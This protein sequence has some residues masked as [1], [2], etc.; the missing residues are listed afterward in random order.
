MKLIFL[1][2]DGVL[3]SREWF[4]TN[5]DMIQKQKTHLTRSLEQLDPAAVKLVSDFANEVNADTVISSTWRRL[6]TLTEIQSLLVVRGWKARLPFA[7][8]PKTDKAFRGDEVRIWMETNNFDPWVTRHVIFDDDSDF[9]PGQPLVQ[10]SFLSG[11]TE[12]HIDLAR[13]FFS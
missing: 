4:N 5:L 7:V 11:I 9:N 6:F 1:D 8:T 10:T 13:G 2:F 3:N 12:A